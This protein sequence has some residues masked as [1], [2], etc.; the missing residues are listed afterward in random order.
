MI[1]IGVDGIVKFFFYAQNNITNGYFL[2]Q[3]NIFYRNR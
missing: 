3:I 1:P 2:S